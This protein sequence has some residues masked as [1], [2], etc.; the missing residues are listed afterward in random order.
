MQRI[1]IIIYLAAIVSANLLI[2]EFG[3]SVSIIN[4]FLLI[5]LDLSLRDYLH[6]VWKE[7]LKRNMALL[8]CAGSGLTILLN[9]EALQIA[10]ASASLWDFCP[11]GLLGL[12]QIK[13]SP[14]PRPF[15]LLQPA[16]IIDRLNPV[17]RAGIRRIPRLDHC[18][19]VCSKVCGWIH[20]ESGN[21]QAPHSRMIHYHG[22]RIAASDDQVTRILKSRHACV[23]Y[24]DLSQLSIVQEVCQSWMLDN[25]AYSFWNSGKTTDWEDYYKFVSDLGP[26]DH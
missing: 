19:T 3:P 24:A 14:V 18:R 7:N 12:P 5:G 21:Q 15:Q 11:A 6:E 13:R 25:G 9:L 17:P 2:L 20:L 26:S 8:I 22:T 23:S 4:A 16:G 10:L 1:A